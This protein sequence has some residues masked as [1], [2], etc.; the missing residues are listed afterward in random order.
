[1]PPEQ[2][3]TSPFLYILIVI[4][5]AALVVGGIVLYRSRSPSPGTTPGGSSNTPGGSGTLPGGSGVVTPGGSTSGTTATTTGDTIPIKTRAGDFVSVYN[6]YPQAEYVTDQNEAGIVNT[7]MYLLYYAAP[8]S[9]FIIQLNNPDVY[10]AREKAESDFLTL[11]RIT[12]TQA[13]ALDVVLMVPPGI[14][15]T[16]AGIDYGLSFCPNGKSLFT[17]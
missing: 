13:C 2:E 3:S 9:Q 5:L 11:L 15:D 1:M 8:Y 14:N 17:P 16:F 4:L 6:F 7:D 12:K 10:A